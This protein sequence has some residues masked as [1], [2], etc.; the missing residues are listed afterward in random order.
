[1]TDHHEVP[2]DLPP[3]LAILNP[4]QKDCLYP[5]KGLAGVGVAFNLII[6]LRS[7]LRKE[8]CL[9]G[10]KRSEPERVPGL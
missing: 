7:H 10:G 5:F 1:V 6:G 9:C 8:G 3:A 2:E 4:K